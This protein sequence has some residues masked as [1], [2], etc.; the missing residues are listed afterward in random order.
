[1][2]IAK[3]I[4]VFR[5]GENFNILKNMRAPKKKKK[6]K[7][8]LRQWAKLQDFCE[9]DCCDCSGGKTKTNPTS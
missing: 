1:M 7:K 3:Q 4:S 6:D 8:G 9:G 5:T 2:K